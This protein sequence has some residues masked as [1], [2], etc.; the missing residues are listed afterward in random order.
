MHYC[1]R[2]PLTTFNAPNWLQTAVHSNHPTGQVCLFFTTLVHFPLMIVVFLW[3]CVWIRV[4]WAWTYISLLRM[5]MNCALNEDAM[6][7]FRSLQALQNSGDSVHLGQIALAEVVTHLGSQRKWDAV[8]KV[9][10]LWGCIVILSSSQ[11]SCLTM[12]PHKSVS[13]IHYVFREWPK[14]TLVR[15]NAYRRVPLWICLHIVK[16]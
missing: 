16:V 8:V 3:L 5:Q 11:P 13:T 12:D 2:V 14:R 10:I 7:V 15:S 6:H 9:C 1:Y 4:C